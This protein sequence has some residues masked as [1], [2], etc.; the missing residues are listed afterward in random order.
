M[1]DVSRTAL[2]PY[3]SSEMYALVSGIE[4]YPQFLPWCSGSQV[5][6][7]GESHV[8]ASIELS[9][10]GI[11]RSFTTLNHHVEE[12]SIHLDLVD[13]PFSRLKGS[14]LFDALA[15]QACRVQFQVSFAFSSTLLGT[16]FGP[17][18]EE[19]CNTLVDAFIRRAE[20]V[21]GKRL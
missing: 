8:K 19:T 12:Q 14:W 4:D 10:A 11:S 20:V 18:F 15:P 3:S 21:Y 6:E 1:K 2:V 16:L 7:R 13:G 5:H 9:R 17:V